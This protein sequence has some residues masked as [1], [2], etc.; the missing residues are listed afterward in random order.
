VQVKHE[1]AVDCAQLAGQTEGYSGADL[2]AIVSEA[3][4]SAVMAHLETLKA[5][6]AAGRPHDNHATQEAPALTAAVRFPALHVVDSALQSSQ[7][8]LKTRKEWF[9]EV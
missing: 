8:C 3:Q 2:R 4:L 5:A 1:D 7:D 6:E 9:L